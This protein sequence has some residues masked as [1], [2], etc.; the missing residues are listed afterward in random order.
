[1]IHS[2]PHASKVS[3]LMYAAIAYRCDLNID[4]QMHRECNDPTLTSHL[5]RA[6]SACIQGVLRMRRAGCGALRCRICC[7]LCCSRHV[8]THW[9]A[10]HGHCAVVH[11]R[12]LLVPR[13]EAVCGCWLACICAWGYT[14]VGRAT[15]SW[16]CG[17]R[18]AVT[19]VNNIRLYF[20]RAL[21]AVVRWCINVRGSEWHSGRC[22]SSRARC[23]Q[24]RRHWRQLRR[25]RQYRLL[26]L[27]LLPLHRRC[28]ARGCWRRRRRLS[29][30]LGR[31]VC[32]RGCRC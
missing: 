5:P 8:G 23:R 30:M 12:I 21:C 22:V 18:L 26:P 28:L 27:L 9:R 2:D 1:M 15:G 32:G 16:R 19:E 4:L 29:S 7:R 24:L 3:V 6:I 14:S 25:W 11:L 20:R 10:M 31:R 17:F 13:A